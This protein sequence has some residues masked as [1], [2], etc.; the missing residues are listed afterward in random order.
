MMPLSLSKCPS[1]DDKLYGPLHLT[2]REERGYDRWRA[3]KRNVIEKK[4]YEKRFRDEN[5]NEFSM[6]D[7]FFSD[8]VAK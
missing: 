2:L 6:S 1:L 5:R 3:V 4:Q 7:L 8:S